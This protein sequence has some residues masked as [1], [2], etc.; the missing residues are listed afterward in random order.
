MNRPIAPHQPGRFARRPDVP[1]AGTN[2]PSG[3]APRRV[4]PIPPAKNAGTEPTFVWPFLLVLAYFF[5]DFGRPQDWFPPFGAVRPGMLVLGGGLIAVIVRRNIVEL[6]TRGKLLVAFL[7]LMVIGTPFATNRFYAFMATRDFALF[8]FGAVVPL[9]CF[10]NTY[11]RLRVLVS[12]FVL[13]HIPLALYCIKNNG[14]GIGSFLGDE[15]DF[16]LA[17]NVILPYAFF[18]LYIFRKVT[19]R[20][21]LIA[22]IGL[23][24]FTITSTLSRGGFVGLVAVALACWLISPRKMMSLIGLAAICAIVATFVPDSY[25]AEMK[26]I[27]TSTDENDTGAQRLYYWGMAWRMFLDHPIL[28]VGPTNYQ[29]NSFQYESADQVAR[30]LH[31]WGKGSHSLYFTLLPEEGLVGAAVYLALIVTGIRNNSRI[32]KTYRRLSSRGLAPELADRLY[33]L[34]ILSRANDVATLGYLVSGAF[35]SVLYYPHFWLQV[36][37]GVAISRIF[38]R[39][40]NSARVSGQENR[41]QP[42]AVKRPALMATRFAH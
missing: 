18:S 17:L 6:G 41:A 8:L 35:L 2:R 22:T 38:D 26:T 3:S 16:C 27:E 10:V 5:I 14:F 21:Y 13:L 19:Q 37:F 33:A 1:S 40:V 7:V 34:N 4:A 25:W 31:V 15:N 39:L 30:G 20:I 42:I 12:F 36:G 29:W 28:G 32:R 24:L 9:M 23:L 11:E